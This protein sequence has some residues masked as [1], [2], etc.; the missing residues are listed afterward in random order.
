MWRG[1][2][3]KRKKPLLQP[4]PGL[5]EKDIATQSSVCTG[6]TLIG[7]RQRRPGSCCRLLWSAVKPT[8]RRFTVRTVTNRHV[9]IYKSMRHTV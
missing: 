6:E 9:R 2:F 1:F 3:K 4:P 8:A 5:G 7:F